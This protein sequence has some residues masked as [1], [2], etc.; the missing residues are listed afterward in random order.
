MPHDPDYV[1]RARD[2]FSRQLVI[3]MIGAKMRRVEAGLVEIELPYRADL[4]Q[5]HGYL[6][7]GIVATIG[8]SAGGYAGYSLMPVAS[9]V[10]TVEYKINLLAPAE[11]ERFFAT[12]RVINSGRTLTICEV[13]VEAFKDGVRTTCAWLLQTL[14]CLENRSDTPS[15]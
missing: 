14:V 13:D 5:Q 9:T 15:R 3:E 6:H 1:H 7:A 12:G 2:S 8:D 11:G 10:L 4:A